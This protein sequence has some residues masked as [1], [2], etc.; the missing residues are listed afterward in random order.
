M[1]GI[2]V[3]D[4]ELE[5]QA[6]DLGRYCQE[7]NIN[8]IV[9]SFLK[10]GD[11]D[12]I[13]KK[14][15]LI[16]N[17]SKIIKP[18]GVALLMHNHEHDVL[19]VTDRDGKEKQIIEVFLERCSKEELMLEIDTGWLEYAGINAVQYVAGNLDRIAVLHLKDICRGFQDMDRDQVFVPCGQGIVDFTGAMKAAAGKEDMIYVLDQ[20]SSKGDITN[21]NIESINYLKGLHINPE[22]RG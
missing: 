17:V 7:N 11:I 16:K 9:L 22:T 6:E 1:K 10:Y 20:D 12:D 18:Y 8:Y 19:L 14:I 3:F 4:E 5:D 2:F 21:D 13:Y 15:D